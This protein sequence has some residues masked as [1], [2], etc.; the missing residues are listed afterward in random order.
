M[1]VQRSSRA[2]DGLR[3]GA[4]SPVTERAVAEL[5]ESEQNELLADR[6]AFAEHLASAFD[7]LEILELMQLL[8]LRHSD[9]ALALGVHPR[10]VR[11]WLDETD[12]RDPNRQRDAILSL[13]ALVLFLLRRGILNPRQLA[14]WLVEP[15]ERLE[16]RR[17]LAVLAEGG[18]NEVVSAS[19]AFVRPE[20]PR[21]LGATTR[22]S[23][24]KRAV[25]AGAAGRDASRPS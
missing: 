12:E 14:L 3:L 21:R 22:D 7:L 13:K 4:G 9:L 11:A 1:I 18:L 25:A 23:P 17:P 2:G 16:F 6:E 19:A 10:T 15:H 24:A 5:S 20:T 8:G